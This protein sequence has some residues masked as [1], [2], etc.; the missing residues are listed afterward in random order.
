MSN[1]SCLDTKQFIKYIPSLNLRFRKV[2]TALLVGQL[3]YWFAKYT[4]GFYKFMEPCE[5]GH[6]RQGDSWTEEL[7]LSRKVFNKAFDLIGIRYKSKAAFEASQDK[8]Q[9]KLY[10]S[11]YDRRQ[12]KTYYRRNHRFLK[13]LFGPKPSQKDPLTPVQ[14]KTSNE[15]PQALESHKPCEGRTV[16]KSSTLKKQG[17]NT[18]KYGPFQNGQQGQSFINKE[19]TKSINISLP[20]KSP[21]TPS[22]NPQ[23]FNT[24]GKGEDELSKKLGE[25]PP[26]PLPPSFCDTLSD[27]DMEKAQHMRDIWIKATKEQIPTPCFGQRFAQKLLKTLRHEFSDKL[28]L[29]QRY[30]ERIGSS[31]FLTGQRGG[32]FQ[33]WLS[34]A[35]KA[36]TIEKV[37]SGHYGVC[38]KEDFLWYSEGEGRGQDSVSQYAERLEASCDGLDKTLKL[39]LLDQ[40]GVSSFKSWFEKATFESV[41]SKTLAVH[42]LS[43]FMASAI[44][45]KFFQSLESIKKSFH[46]QEILWIT[47]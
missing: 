22:R 23:A 46:V 7:C 29:W 20:P 31:K 25:N 44:Q 35:I 10:A 27:H 26:R 28:L 2:E 32:G 16:S 38:M 8:F 34:R 36:E 37:Q 13:V 9:G 45:A 1:G 47:S 18:Q 42:G 21:T 39:F 12:N 3:E 30:C 17:K 15:N 6:Y 43:P 5:H 11:Y 40:V 4:Q 19:D 41:D 24:E 14:L 33:L